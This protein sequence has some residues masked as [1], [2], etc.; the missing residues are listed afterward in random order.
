MLILLRGN[1]F[2]IVLP[3][4]FW[5]LLTSRQRLYSFG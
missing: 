3:L 1:W 4:L 2:T 5:V